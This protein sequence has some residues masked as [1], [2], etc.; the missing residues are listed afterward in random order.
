MAWIRAVLLNICKRK[1]EAAQYPR[2]VVPI[3]DTE[4]DPDVWGM[5]FPNEYD[6]FMKMQDSTISTP[7]GGSVPYDTLD[8]GPAMVRF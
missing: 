4:L 2:L 6:S 1:D 8:R 5:N 3:S 7:Y